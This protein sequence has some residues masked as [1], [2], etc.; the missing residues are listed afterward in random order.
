MLGR[1]TWVCTA[2]PSKSPIPTGSTALSDGSQRRRSWPSSARPPLSRNPQHRPPT[3]FGSVTPAPTSGLTTTSD[4]DFKRVLKRGVGA[5]NSVACDKGYAYLTGPSSGG[6]QPF[7]MIVYDDDAG[8]GLP[9]SLKGVSDEVVLAQGAAAGWVSFPFSTP[10]QIAGDQLYFGLISGLGGVS[11]YNYS[12][13]PGGGYRLG[14]TY[15]DGASNPFGANPLVLAIEP[16]FVLDYTISGDT[17]APVF[18]SATVQA[19]SLQLH[20]SE[21]LDQASIPASS[22]FTVTVNGQL[23]SL[24]TVVGMSGADVQ[25]FL[26]NPVLAGDIVTIAYTQPGSNAIQ[27][28][29]GNKALSLGPQSVANDTQAIGGR[30]IS[31]AQRVAVARRIDPT[32]RRA[33]E[34]GG[35]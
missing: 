10:A 27:D 18:Q 11:S 7:R 5:G 3:I 35:L 8:G 13:V 21:T 20:Y 4:A 16:G 2:S 26:A 28:L 12:N 29:V 14:D 9:G 6:G 32:D 31:P 25:V 23:W 34:G 30:I 33:G 24:L 19:G 22:A 17:V 15:A 1:C